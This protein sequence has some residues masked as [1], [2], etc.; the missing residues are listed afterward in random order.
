[1]KYIIILFIAVLSIAC[2]EKKKPAKQSKPKPAKVSQTVQNTPKKKAL[3]G[4]KIYLKNCTLC[5]GKDGK[6]GLS[7]SKDLTK[8]EMTLDEQILIVTEGKGTMMS[9]AKLLSAD[10]IKSVA[11]YTQS[12]K[13]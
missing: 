4:K 5:H 11:E 9:Y 2:G 8:S 12:L 10:E 7:G 6:L 1:M 3:P 13:K